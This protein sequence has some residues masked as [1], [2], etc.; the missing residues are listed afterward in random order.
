MSDLHLP[1]APENSREVACVQLI[2]GFNNR[3]RVYAVFE[4]LERKPALERENT[5]PESK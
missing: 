4:K 5:S 3:G 2:S 1:K